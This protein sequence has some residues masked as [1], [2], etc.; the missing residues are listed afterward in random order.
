V[1]ERVC[2]RE[3]ERERESE[4]MGEKRLQLKRTSIQKIS[5]GPFN[6]NISWIWDF[7]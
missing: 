3:R 2:K 7:D 4:A 6:S 1:R 5:T